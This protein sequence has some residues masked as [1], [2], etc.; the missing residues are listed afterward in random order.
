MKPRTMNH[1]SKQTTFVA[2]LGAALALTHALPAQSS[3]AEIK[4]LREQ[5]AALDQ[6]LRVLERKQE[7][8]EEEAAAAA[9]SAAK[10]TVNDKGFTFASQD[11]ANSLRIRGL[12]QGDARLFFSDGGIPNNDAL[13]LRRARLGAEG[14]FNKIFEYQFVSEFGGSSTSVL[15]ANINLALSKRFQIR[16]GKFKS[17]VGLEQLQSDSWAFFTERAYPS[18]LVGNR[19]LGIYLSGEFADG[20]VGW[21]AGVFNGLG[22]GASTTNSD[23]DDEKELVGRLFFTPFKNSVGSPVQGLGFGIAASTTSTSGAAGL[24]G[25]YRTDGQQTFF[26]YRSTVI[27][28]GD[29]RRVSPQAYWYNGPFG[30]LGEYVESVSNPRVGAAGVTREIKNAAWQLAGSWV[31]TGEDT[32]YKGVVPKTTFDLSAKTW[33]ALELTARIANLDIDDDA[34]TLFADPSASASEATSIG[35]GLNWYLSKSLRA[36][37]DYFQTHFDL[38]PGAPAL[39]SNLVIRQDEKSFISRLQLTF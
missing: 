36:S 24:T 31:I 39:P 16:V 37:F 18:Q 30:L 15:D 13:V 32:S 34:F 9:K 3:D 11:G 12:V 2:A 35:V 10:V 14:F 1:L 19:D 25:G 8:K 33:G 38:A 20:V 4:A 6:K 7:I 26:R 17:P 22:D 28:D 21:G 29:L 5:I 23:V 27:Q